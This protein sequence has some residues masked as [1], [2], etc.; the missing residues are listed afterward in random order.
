MAEKLTDQ[1]EL[2]TG[3]SFDD[4]LYLVDVS[5]TTE[6]AAGSSFKIKVGNLL[7]LLGVGVTIPGYENYTVKK[8]TGNTDL[9]TIESGDLVE[10]TNLSF[11]GGDYVVALCNT[12]NPTV[13][14]DFDTPLFR[15]ASI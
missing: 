13:D 8:G 4:V 11:F 9:T 14:G 3:L 7:T 12:D 6:D 1:T 10:G 2:T 5:D 15:A